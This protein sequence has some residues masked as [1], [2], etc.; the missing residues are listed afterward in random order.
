MADAKWAAYPVHSAEFVYRPKNPGK[1]PVY[2]TMSFT[3]TGAGL[4]ASV[5]WT[6]KMAE[7]FPDGQDKL[8]HQHHEKM[9][10]LFQNGRDIPT[11]TNPYAK[12]AVEAVL[13]SLQ[14]LKENGVQFD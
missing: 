3:I 6:Q 8:V 14:W 9:L 2:P 12:L 4:A 1:C 5:A 13:I 10:D 11:P 7:K